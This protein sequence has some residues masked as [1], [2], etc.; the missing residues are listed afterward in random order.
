V[1]PASF[2]KKL[3][4]GTSFE[5]SPE[6]VSLTPKAWQ[7]ADRP[8]DLHSRIAANGTPWYAKMRQEALE[9]TEHLVS[10][11]KVRYQGM[12]SKKEY[13]TE[14]TRSK[15]CF[16]PFGYGEVCW[17]DY[18]A[19]AR[20]ALLLKPDMSHITMNANPFR[21]YETYVPL[22]WD[23]S[24]LESKVDYYLRHESERLRISE[25]AFNSLKQ[26]HSA[27]SFIAESNGLWKIFDSS[28]VS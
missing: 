17:R 14:L 18:E 2:R 24:D 4:L 7:P 27:E 25:N 20:G 16:S 21:A 12:V 11:F 15:M 8:I 22:S 13:V 5:Q 3:V 10:K 6:I 9:A 1:I 28:E 23:L 19:M 26:R